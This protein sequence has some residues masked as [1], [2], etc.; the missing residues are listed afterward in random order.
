MN[1]GGLVLGENAP[2]LRDGQ[3]RNPKGI[4]DPCYFTKADRELFLG[5]IE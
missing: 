2:N 4:A 5:A 1:D 3:A